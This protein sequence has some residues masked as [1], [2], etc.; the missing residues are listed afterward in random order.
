MTAVSEMAACSGNSDTTA[1]GLAGAA[2]ATGLVDFSAGVLALTA[3]TT[4]GATDSRGATTATGSA[5]AT[6]DSRGTAT[7]AGATAAG[8]TTASAAATGGHTAALSGRTTP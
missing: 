7:A 2:A 3:T 1:T 4:A 8:R 6:A 5:A